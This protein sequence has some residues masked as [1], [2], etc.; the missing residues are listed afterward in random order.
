MIFEGQFEADAAIFNVSS[1]FTAKPFTWGRY[2][3]KGV[4]PKYL[5]LAEFREVGQQPPDPI[6]LTRRLAELHKKSISPTG[7]FDFH[8]TTCHAK[9][10]KLTDFWEDSW[11]ICY[12]RQLKHTFDRDSD[13]MPQ[14]P[15][16]RAVA[17]LV[18]NTCV[19]T[20]LRPLQADGRTIKPCLI[21]GNVWDGN[22]ATDMKTGE[23][24]I[25]DGSAMYAHNEYEI[26]NWRTR[27]HRL[28]S[29]S[30]IKNYKTF[31]PAS[32]PGENDDFFNELYHHALKL[33]Q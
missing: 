26:G 13:K 23:P 24:F 16:F 7:K 9:M 5:L 32:E 30:Y 28:S 12:S 29:P 14:W 18:L 10:D 21:H 27:R 22:T 6:R 3:R 4:S 2:E 8:T 15:E 11:E 1:T 33:Y 19:P 25:F 17:D 31:F 20:L